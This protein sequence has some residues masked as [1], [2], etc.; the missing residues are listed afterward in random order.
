MKRLLFIVI[1]SLMFL[2]CSQPELE[3]NDDSALLA[4][5][6]EKQVTAEF[7]TAVFAA[8]GITNPTQMQ[9]AQRL[10]Q[11]LGQ[12]ALARVAEK[13]QQTLS[14]QQQYILQYLRI[15]AEAQMAADAFLK[16]HPVTD[17]EIEQEY[18]KV[19][20]VAG[21]QQYLVHHMLFADEL[22]AV[23]ALDEIQAGLSYLDAQ[24]A[25]LQNYPS[26]SNVGRLGWVN[27]P[28][29]PAAFRTILP[30]M[31]ADTVHP[32]VVNSRFGNHVVYLEAVKGMEKP[33]LEDSRDGLI[34]TLQKR[35]LDKYQQLVK[36][37]ADIKLVDRVAGQ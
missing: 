11:L 31:Q 35:K 7:L 12:M 26:R 18:Q 5:V 23:E 22:K 20:Q 34:R 13:E 24:E 30:V 29:L 28:Q 2:A 36:I 19:T 9:M 1:I 32:E 6:D 16:A 4:L 27:L 25:Y 17:E 37:K 8:E 21:D 14:V 33:S 3:I 15:K 10:D